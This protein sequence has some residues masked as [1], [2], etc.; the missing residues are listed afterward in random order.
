[1]SSAGGNTTAGWGN[2]AIPKDNPASADPSF[3]PEVFAL[4]FKNPW[5]CSFDSGKPSY[6]YCADVGQVG[7]S[8]AFDSFSAKSL[9]ISHEIHES[10]LTG[11]IVPAHLID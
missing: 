4:G 11:K 5:R 7:N 6:M 2:Y 1:M 9:T 3:A 10:S 8:C